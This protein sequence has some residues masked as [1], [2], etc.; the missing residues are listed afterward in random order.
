M[1]TVVGDTAR[2]LIEVFSLFVGAIAVVGRGSGNPDG[3]PPS[4]LGCN[5]FV[6]GGLLGFRSLDRRGLLRF[7]AGCL[8]GFGCSEGCFGFSKQVDLGCVWN[9]AVLGEDET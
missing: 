3:L 6:C 9:R 1:A 8:F 5:F 2:V 7:L 4:G